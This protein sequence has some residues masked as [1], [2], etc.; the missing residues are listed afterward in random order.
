VLAGGETLQIV[1]A[2]LSSVQQLAAGRWCELHQSAAVAIVLGVIAVW[3]AILSVAANIVEDVARKWIGRL[4]ASLDTRLARWLRSLSRD[5]FR[6]IL[7]LNSGPGMITVWGGFIV[8][9]AAAIVAAKAGLPAALTAV[10]RPIPWLLV[11]ISATSQL[12]SAKAFE[13]QF[14]D[15]FKLE[16]ETKA[17]EPR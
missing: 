8:A 1:V 17:R 16:S 5:Q 14:C 10:I 12:V 13:L 7:W 6:R 9:F 4:S 11:L 15:E 2:R 3:L